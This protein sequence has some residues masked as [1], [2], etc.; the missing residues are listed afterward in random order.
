[1]TQGIDEYETASETYT[2]T[3]PID[4]KAIP[5]IDGDVRTKLQAG[6]NIKLLGTE[7][8][9]AW[10]EVQVLAEDANLHGWLNRDDMQAISPTPSESALEQIPPTTYDHNSR[11]DVLDLIQA[12][13]TDSE[14]EFKVSGVVRQATVWSGLILAIITLPLVL[15]NLLIFWIW[16]ESTST[17][18]IIVSLGF[19]DLLIW[20]IPCLIWIFWV[21]I[22]RSN[23]FP[24]KT[25]NRLHQIQRNKRSEAEIREEKIKTATTMAVGGGIIVAI[26]AIFL[27]S[28]SRPRSRRMA[29]TNTVDLNAARSTALQAQA[30]LQ[31]R[32]AHQEE[33]HQQAALAAQAAQR[34]QAKLA[35][36][37]QREQEQRWQAQQA[38][39]RLEAERAEAKRRQW[40]QDVDQERMDRGLL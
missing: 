21:S 35:A 1:M 23:Y 32:Q 14:Q 2:T 33:A 13:K 22:K 40:E 16:Y 25:L 15:L 17:A 19:L 39:A 6:A 20:S 26:L 3:H 18:E 27:K 30:A 29:S 31:A 11:Q 12:I 7:F 4:L 8:E 9:Q 28:N 24:T 10:V 5:H 37:Q 38:E 34:Q 36:Q